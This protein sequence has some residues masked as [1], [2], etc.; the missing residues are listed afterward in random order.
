MAAEASSTMK[1]HGEAATNGT[2]QRNSPEQLL[3]PSGGQTTACPVAVP[4]ESHLTHSLAHVHSRSSLSTAKDAGKA[5]LR[6]SWI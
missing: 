4:V 2:V 6:L 3:M 5:P 1:L